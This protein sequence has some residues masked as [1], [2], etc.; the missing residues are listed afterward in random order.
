MDHK[1]YS[2]C[3]FSQKSILITNINGREYGAVSLQ[4]CQ[5]QTNKQNTQSIRLTNTDDELFHGD[6]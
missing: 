6:S 4:M 3:L 2:S 5:K 1:F